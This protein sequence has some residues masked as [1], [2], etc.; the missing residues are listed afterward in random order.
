MHGSTG[1]CRQIQR[2]GEPP[3]SARLNRLQQA[4]AIRLKPKHLKTGHFCRTLETALAHWISGFHPTITLFVFINLQACL[5]KL[6][7][8]LGCY[9][10]SFH[11]IRLV[12]IAGR[13]S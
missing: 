1:W 5:L 12:R 3:T 10:Y 6:G 9:S 8:P 11:Y 13:P 2:F 4:C 7:E